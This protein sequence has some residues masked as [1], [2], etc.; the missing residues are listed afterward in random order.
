[1]VDH[2]DLIDPIAE[3]QRLQFKD[4]ALSLYLPASPA[5]D[6]AFHHALLKDLLRDWSNVMSGRRRL[7]LDREMKRTRRFFDERSAGGRP[8]AIFACEPASLF[9]VYRLPQD[10]AA[11]LWVDRQLHLNPLLEMLDRHTESLIVA[12]DKERARVFRRVLTRLDRV[13]ELRGEPIKRQRQGGWSAE[14][15][16][17]H[18]DQK[19]EGNV[20]AAVDWIAAHRDAYPGPITV[21]GPPEARAQLLRALPDSLQ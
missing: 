20:Q 16:Q 4:F 2:N 10:V 17:R 11:Q 5:L 21:I 9:E 13:A 6:Q 8:L 19:S 12:V 3:L 15:F 1:M 7:A 14:K 18:E